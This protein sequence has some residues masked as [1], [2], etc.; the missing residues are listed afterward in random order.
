[1]IQQ[2]EPSR[3]GS[4]DT[5]YRGD[6]EIIVAKA[7]EKDK[8]RR[9]ASA[10]DLASDIRRYL[11]GEAILARP[12]SALYQLRKF[13]RRN[14]ALVGGVLGVVGALVLGLVGTV[15]FAVQAGSNARTARDKEKRAVTRP[16]GHGSRR[17]LRRSSTTTS[18]TQHTNSTRPPKSCG[19]GSGG[20]CTAASTTVQPC[21]QSNPV[22]SLTWS[23][24]RKECA[25][26]PSRA[27][28]CDS[29]TSTAAS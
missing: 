16:I 6:V 1:M 18:L 28:A 9:Y 12:A 14:K 2:Q 20:T 10:G 15:L 17:P 5:H 3:L 29:S 13:A 19:A 22:R 7:L 11:R 4:I 26:R 21:F 8:T 27:P 23:T 25:W 24:V